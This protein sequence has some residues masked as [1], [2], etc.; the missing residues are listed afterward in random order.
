MGAAQAQKI[1]CTNKGA[2]VMNFSVRWLDASGVWH[3]LDWN[4][5]NYDAGKTRTSPDLATLG[6]P[7]D[8]Q[9]V[10]PYVHAILGGYGVGEPYVVYGA[11]AG[12]ATYH[13]HGATFGFSVT[14][15][16][17]AST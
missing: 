8:A 2:F 4:S 17:P 1:A 13:V 14:L 11:E 15:E 7:T 16:T 6:V 12:V 5:G 10:A 9:F 3:T